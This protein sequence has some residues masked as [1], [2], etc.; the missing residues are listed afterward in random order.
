MAQ[1]LD[2]GCLVEDGGRVWV[3][4][5]VAALDELQLGAEPAANVAPL[6]CEDCDD[7]PAGPLAMLVQLPGE[8]PDE[9]MDVQAVPQVGDEITHDGRVFV[10]ARRRMESASVWR[11]LVS[12][13]AAHDWSEA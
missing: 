12:P 10:V 2:A 11:V 1:A 13:M 8:P 7:K 4:H 3:Q 5:D 6:E 9:P